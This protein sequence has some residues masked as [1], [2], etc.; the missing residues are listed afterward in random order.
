LPGAGAQWL[1]DLA[2]NGSGE[3][4][5]N[6]DELPDGWA[7]SSYRSPA[8]TAWDRDV[9]HT[10]SASMRVS[11]SKHPTETA[12][13]SN[14]GRWISRDRKAVTAGREYTLRAFVKAEGV[15]GRATIAIAWF[16]GNSW[17]AESHS[18]PVTGTTDW[19]KVALAATAPAGADASA[20]YLC[21]SAS[22]GTVWF[23]TVCMAEGADRPRDH[24]FVDIRQA[25]NAGFR[26]EVAGD[27]RGGWTDQ[28]DND[29]RGIPLGLQSW[30]GAP[31]RIIDPTSNDGKSC[32]V[33]RGTGR[34]DFPEAASLQVGDTCD[35]V[36]FLHNCGWAS[37]AAGPVAQYTVSYADGS[38]ER[39]QL[40]GGRE[41]VD[42]WNPADTNESAVGWLGRNPQSPTVG[43]S[44]F[45]WRNPRPQSA[46]ET[47]RF[48]KGSGDP[49]PILVAVTLANG[50]PVLAE[51]PLQLD[52]TDTA[53]WYPFEF[54][55]DDATLEEI[56]LSFL[57]DAPAGKHGFVT[58]GKDGHLRFQD[59][60]PAR[61]FGVDIGG[62]SACPEREVAETTAARLARIGINMVRLHAV[63]AGYAPLIDYERGDSR[64]LNAEALDRYDYFVAELKKHG[65]Y[66]YFD[67]LDY[68]KFMDADGV[69]EA[70]QFQRPWTNSIKGSSCYD[71]RMIE[72][73]KEYATQ[74][75]T[76]RNP[77]TGNR[78]V[79]EPAMA[80]LEITNENSVFY[81]SNT[82]LT[83]PTYFDDLRERWNGWLAE[84]HGNRAGLARAWTNVAG[85]CA[86]LADEDPAK[87]SVLF[88]LR[89]L[90]A[91]LSDASYV[92]QKSP[93]RLNAMTRFLYEVTVAYYT[94]MRAHL[95]SIGVRIPI[96]GTNQD[97]S[98]ASNF[99][100]YECD[101]M[102]RNNY[103]R[104]PNVRAKPY[105]TFRND[106]LL[107]SDVLATANPIAN[108]AS[109][110]AAGKPMVVPEFNFP[111]PN[112]YRAE[113]LPLVACYARLQ[114]WDGLIMHSYSPRE[115]ILSFFRFQSDPVRWGQIPLAA[116]LFL[117]GDVAAARTTV[118]VGHSTPDIFATRARRTS[119]EYCPYRYLPYISKVRNAYF[120]D[121]YAGKADV[122]IASGHSAAGSYAKAKRA[123]VFADNPFA[124]EAASEPARETSA[125]ATLARLRAVPALGPQQLS[126]DGFMWPEKTI[127]VAADT[128]L[129]R[130][131][132]P[133]RATPFGNTA[134]GGRSLGSIDRRLCIAPH[135]SALQEV[136]PAWPHRLYL[137]AAAHWELPGINTPSEAGR[138]FRSDTGEL[139]LNAEAGVFTANAR[140]VRGAVGYLGGIGAIALGEVTLTCRT[141]FAAVTLIAL[142]GKPIR[143]SRRLLLTAVAR[144]EN[145]G[146]AFHRDRTTTPER[147]RRPVVAEPVDCDVALQ[148]RGAL[149]AWSLTP[150][151]AK[152]T[153]VAV[154]REGRALKLNPVAAGS[155]WILLEAE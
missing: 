128:L 107:R 28:G 55:L 92:G 154:E 8:E 19:T 26:D 109:S 125:A 150:T 50:P 89:D 85:E 153:E 141:P 20:I 25:A 83:L 111:W 120:E 27:G 99:A 67:L 62:G 51:A 37:R 16:K 88:P 105:V 91:D 54:A 113:A 10:G 38:Q 101:F 140:R 52:F 116:L 7:P 145:T 148:R 11:D 93:A 119:D 121:D 80:L 103:W 69:K 21:L 76:H 94:E 95:R 86:L 71:P 24:R 133:K 53:D 117:R 1:P 29:A 114:G 15:T 149:T 2:A 108:I 142:D 152:Q 5:M 32:I 112:E 77:Y 87:R 23:D 6:R 100:N 146:Q 124:D 9:A 82:Q 110:T 58:V 151:G 4:D 36:Y 123:I 129:G 147:G 127:E 46:I 64:H 68:R 74:L 106:S 66:C 42:W 34:E 57:L 12:W 3:L 118:H 96:T 155:P 136:D 40:R 122:A 35:V 70:S 60:T 73:Q 59:G 97:F 31:F 126:F 75:L 49:V 18:D 72:L 48:E 78:Y 90:Y 137:A 63:D 44:I 102:S 65:I 30:R 79:D 45:P 115:G 17:V 22:K 144:A 98:D 81:M 41:I 39:I 104:H 13:D 43:L 139:V 61:F 134:D 47:I 130:A 135:V 131:T 33:L 84:R 132:L 56:D 14:A 143:S 138:V